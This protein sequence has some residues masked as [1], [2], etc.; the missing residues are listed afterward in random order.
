MKDDKY[1]NMLKFLILGKL[2]C[3]IL[4]LT[5]CFVYMAF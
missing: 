5:L 1:K 2:F 3:I 4:L